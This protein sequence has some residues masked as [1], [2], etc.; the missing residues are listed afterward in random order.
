MKLKELKKLVKEEYNRY[1]KEQDMP[2]MPPMPGNGI[3]DPTIAV[4]DNDIDLEGGE[5][6]EDTLKAIFDMLKDFF[7]GE[8][9]AG[10]APAPKADK[11]GD[12]K[13]DKGGAK[14]GDKKDDKGG[15]K[16][17]DK[18][19]D[20]KEKDALQ[21][22]RKKIRARRNRS[23]KDMKALQERFKTLANIIK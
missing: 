2:E 11:G 15:D 5:S 17:D 9:D 16:K 23:Q 14:G 13:D 1:L 19:K 21:E 22:S 3:E 8:G 7:E 18:E 4:S 6:P 20:D 12:K 10:G